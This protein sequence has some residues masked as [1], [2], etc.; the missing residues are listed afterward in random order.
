[1][2]LTAIH[3]VFCN[4]IPKTLDD[5]VLYISEKFS[6]AAHNCCCGCGTK[7]VTPLK[8]GR[9]SMHNDNGFVS[10]NPSVGNWSSACQ[11]H[12]WIEANQ[13]HWA[14]GF[15]ESQIRANRASDQR[16][17]AQAHID[18]HLLEQGFWGRLWFRI[19]RWLGLR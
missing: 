4:R 3:P 15:T 1:M 16:A 2:K 10:L 5:G 9:W 6:T 18:R 8:P 17:S 11:S 13:V 14:H 12:Y 7:I 19:K